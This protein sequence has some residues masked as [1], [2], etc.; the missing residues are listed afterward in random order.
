MT[1]NWLLKHLWCVSH[2]G[3]RV[4][5]KIKHIHIIYIKHPSVLKCTV[6]AQEKKNVSR[7]WSLVWLIKF[8]SHWFLQ[9]RREGEKMIILEAKGPL[10]T[11]KITFQRQ[12]STSWP[13]PCRSPAPPT[14]AYRL[15]VGRFL[16]C[17]IKPGVH[18]MY[19]AQKMFDYPLNFVQFP[20]THTE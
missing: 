2:T 19:P 20:K 6:G 18:F 8:Q 15:C 12:T 3:E 17:Q 7:I 16:S 10:H 5:K 11:Q 1:P 14:W 9:I 4:L 13:W